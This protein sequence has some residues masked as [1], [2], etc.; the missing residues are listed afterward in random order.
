M[1]VS[2]FLSGIKKALA[3]SAVSASTAVKQPHDEAVVETSSED[4]SEDDHSEHSEEE[5]PHQ[6][7]TRVPGKRIAAQLRATHSS[8]AT[9]EATGANDFSTLRVAA[10]NESSRASAI[11]S[12]A[13]RNTIRRAGGAAADRKRPRSTVTETL[14]EELLRERDRLRK[15][16]VGSTSIPIQEAHVDA[17]SQVKEVMLRVDD[18]LAEE[19]HGELRELPPQD[20]SS[21]DGVITDPSQRVD[22]LAQQHVSLPVERATINGLAELTPEQPQTS[23]HSVGEAAPSPLDGG[24]AVPAEKPQKPKKKLRLFQLATA[25]VQNKLD[26]EAI[27]EGPETMRVDRL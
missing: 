6:M 4:G 26:E 16:I 21:T 18:L 10:N 7:I 22:V 11:P 14:R 25:I 27:A 20:H 5:A 23:T 12:L 17:G 19:Q 15:T 24:E 3:T 1:D 8:T 9:R 2:A 13:R